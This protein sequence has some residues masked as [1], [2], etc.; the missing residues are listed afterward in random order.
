[1]TYDVII[2]CREFVKKFLF[3]PRGPYQWALL[4]GALVTGGEPP[5]ILQDLLDKK[6]VVAIPHE[7]F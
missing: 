4:K 7:E 5:A 3:F 6:E 2:I 1:M